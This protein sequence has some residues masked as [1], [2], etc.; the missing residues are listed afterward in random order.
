LAGARSLGGLLLVALVAALLIGPARADTVWTLSVEFAG[1]GGGAVTSIDDVINCPSSSPG[2]PG[3]STTYAPA[4]S[5][6]L[7]AAAAAGSYFAGWSGG[8]SGAAATDSFL[9]PS[10]DTT[11]TAE[12]DDGGGAQSGATLSVTTGADDAGGLIGELISPTCYVNFCTLRDALANGS[13]KTIVFAGGVTTITPTSG[14][15]AGSPGSPMIVDGGAGVTI[16]ASGVSSAPAFSMSGGSVTL[17]HV[18]VANDAGGGGVYELGGTLVLQHVTVTN[19]TKG[20]GGTPQDGGIHAAGTLTMSDSTISQNHAG[21]CAGIDVG[22]TATLTN[23]VIDGNHATSVG[24]GLCVSPGGT[25]TVTGGIIENNVAPKSS[26]AGV[27]SGTL[28]SNGTV[29]FDNAA[30]DSSGGSGLSVAKFGGG[31][32]TAT[33]TNATFL[34]NSGAYAIQVDATSTVKIVNST[35]DDNFGGI[36]GPTTLLNTILALNDTTANCGT[37]PT[38][39][40]HNIEDGTSCG[41]SATGDHSSLD[42]LLGSSTPDG[43]IPLHNGSP[44]LDTGATG[45]VSGVTVPAK[46]ALGTNRPQGG[47]VDIGA[48]EMSAHKLTVKTAGLGKGTVSPDASPATGGWYVAGSTVMLTATPDGVSAFGAWSGACSGTNAIYGVLMSA[49]GTCTATFVLKPLVTSFSPAT[50]RIHATVTMLGKGFTGATSVTFNGHDALSFHVF[51]DTKITAVVP[52]DATTGAIHVA[53]PGG[54]FSTAGDFIVKWVAPKIASFAPAKAG[55]GATVTINGTG[56]FGAGGVAFNGVPA[57]TYTVVSDTKITAVVPADPSSTG[58]VTLSTTGGPATS[59]ASFTFL[60]PPFINAFAPSHAAFGGVIMI[61]GTHFIGTKTVSFTGGAAKFKVVADTQ[62]NVTVPTTADT[63]KIT[64]TNGGGATQTATDFTLDWI[65]PVVTSFTPVKGPVLSTVTITGSHF[66]RASS[67]AIGGHPAASYKVVSDTKITAVV[68]YNG[69]T[70]AV[71]VGNPGGTGASAAL[72]T[73]TW[74]VPKIISFTPASGGPFSTVTITGTGIIGATAMYLN[75]A[76]ILSVTYLSTTKVQV[77]VPGA[78][79]TG[80]FSIVTLG[81][82]ALSSGI[83]TVS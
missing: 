80:K 82:T 27:A 12:F 13:G 77:T 68:P 7:I 73:I 15:D 66:T 39:L 4:A 38:S 40:G 29:F 23:T 67:V 62:L 81:G 79:T 36:S 48:I 11:C 30:S 57:G 52:E 25:A 21:I 51:S 69:V 24:G 49:D 34:A 37:P 22:G 59:T 70:S 50:A 78:A 63:G 16:D 44:A 43:F 55:G 33:L 17:S 41:L 75:G 32:G 65:T 28:T 74:P 26:G 8:C 46:D 20:G 56:F 5:V 9:M 58:H 6:M 35:I 72:F 47:G 42:P 31:D 19:N 64:I 14:L 54:G 2:D 60:P 18:T 71:Y 10:A 61:T 45:T 3:C 83:F 53:A 1:T 76:P